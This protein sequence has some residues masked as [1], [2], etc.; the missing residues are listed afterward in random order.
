LV[1]V[2]EAVTA[3]APVHEISRWLLKPVHDAFGG[4]LRLIFCGGAFTDRA[5]AAFFARLGLPV[6]IGYG[7]TEATTVV[8]VNDLRPFRGDSVGRPVPGVR[9]RIDDPDADGVG[10]VLVAGPTVFAGYLDDPEQ[11][12]AAF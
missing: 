9:V 4:K 8:T 11:T 2:N 3:R 12:A 10:E 5:R 7:L 1:A 6:A